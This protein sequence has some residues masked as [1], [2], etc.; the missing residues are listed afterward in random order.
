MTTYI[1]SFR[2]MNWF[3]NAIVDVQHR[4]KTTL[5][6][7]PMLRIPPSLMAANDKNLKRF[8]QDC[9]CQDHLDATSPLNSQV[10]SA[11]QIINFGKN[12][13]RL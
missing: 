1:R 7:Y 9:A 4:G 13:G 12:Y 2:R 5:Y 3:V 10:L 8:I 6:R 11:E